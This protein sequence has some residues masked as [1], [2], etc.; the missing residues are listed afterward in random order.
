MQGDAHI[1]Q[2]FR[3]HCDYARK[4]KSRGYEQVGKVLVWHVIEHQSPILSLVHFAER[5]KQ[6]DHRAV[7]RW[8]KKHYPRHLMLVPLKAYTEFLQGLFACAERLELYV[9][10][11]RL[12]QEAG[13]PDVKPL[14]PMLACL[15][16]SLN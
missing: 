3:L 8:L 9:L 12:E 6:R 5:L 2:Q 13:G 1:S 7:I 4:G 16:P 10:P 14:R 11:R 15:R